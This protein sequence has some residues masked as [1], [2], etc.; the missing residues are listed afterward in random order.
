MEHRQP[1]SPLPIFEATSFRSL[2]HAP[3]P[4][5]LHS[6]LSEYI[7]T[8]RWFRGKAR[9]I[10]ALEVLDQ[11]PLSAAAHEVS[12]IVLCVQYAAD[13][14]ESYV[15]P[16]ACA[17]TS[18]AALFELRLPDRTRRVV[19]DP[20]GEDALSHSLLE[21][22]VRAKTEGESGFIEAR[23]SDF[24][25][26]R[27]AAGQPPLAPRVPSGEQSNTS[28][29]FGEE[30]MLK[31]FRQLEP[32]ENPDVELHRFLWASGF[33]H[34]AEPLGSVTYERA[35]FSSTLGIAQRFVPSEGTAWEVTLQTLRQS[36]ELA[37]SL[38]PA[39]AEQNMPNSDL[40]DSSRQ[41]P[42]ESI[43]AFLAAYV[44]FAKLLAERTAQ[45]HVALA[46]GDD[47]AAFSPEPFTPEYQR[48][49]VGSTRERVERGHRLLAEQL[50]GL[51]AEVRSSAREVLARRDAFL[52]RLDALEAVQVRASR[53]RCHGDYH[54]GQV[55]YG[56]RDFTILDFEGEPAQPLEARRLKRS[57]LYDVCGMLR[58][59]HYA[60]TVALHAE[61]W[62]PEERT[63][64][65]SWSELWYRWTCALF[66]SAY[67]RK[68]RERTPAVFLP[69]APEELRALLQLHLID[70]C[71][72]ELSYE[73]NNRP[74]WAFVPLAG[75]LGLARAR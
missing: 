40:L 45:L 20:S 12:L 50:A 53:I 43:Q 57:A 19:S 23:P 58:S 62:Q 28:V 67:L 44:P 52:G 69:E 37:R 9:S 21:L 25:K 24:L 1:A 8:R 68:A 65:A 33:R 59:F 60:A 56:A 46:S 63:R 39:Q 15:L 11:L 38:D 66:L 16:F 29:F 73:L 2:W 35:G 17:A 10:R 22:F 70:K 13:P 7:R 72:Y 41:A 51:P 14:A 61:D 71:S 47:L 27:L 3:L 55:L 31:L 5:Q 49:I 36:F 18:G 34:V 48:S 75:L 30:L 6:L 64:L 32:G 26:T 4:A 42:P 74:A 54:L